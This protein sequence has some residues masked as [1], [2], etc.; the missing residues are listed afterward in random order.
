MVAMQDGTSVMNEISSLID[1]ETLFASL[2]D[3][4][5]LAVAV[6]AENGKIL[7]ANDAIAHV[8][9]PDHTPGRTITGRTI[10]DFRSAASADERVRVLKAALDSGD[11]VVFDAT[12]RGVRFRYVVRPI[13]QRIDGLRAV[14]ITGRPVSTPRRV[15]DLLDQIDPVKP[16]HG[17]QFVEAKNNDLGALE[18]LTRRELEVLS[19]IGQGLSTQAIANKLGRSVK[20]IEGHRVSLGVKLGVTNR[21][22]L[23]RIAIRAGLAPFD[24]SAD[25]ETVS[26]D[27]N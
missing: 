7:Y 15:G 19:Y 25:G 12:A 2:A 21:V 26:A 3:D 4:S 14:L 27:S 24:A 5:G 18:N 6:V 1:Q 22:E 23:A 10:H 11:P 9:D 17:V 20:T 8:L 16:N 13:D